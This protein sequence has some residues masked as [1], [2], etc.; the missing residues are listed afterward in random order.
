MIRAAIFPGRYVQGRDAL[1]KISEFIRPF[2][3][4]VTLL[5]DQRVRDF[6]ETP[7]R[8]ALEAA[9]MQFQSTMFTGE[10][11]WKE[12]ERVVDILRNNGSEIIIGAGGGKTIETA[13]SA[14]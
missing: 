8:T 4:S 11:S 1:Q 10:S 5:Y 14:L 7:L 2:G 6:T 13:S 3:T 9:G 12:I